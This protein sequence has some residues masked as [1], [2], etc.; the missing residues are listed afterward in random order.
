MI[1]KIRPK[2]LS[3]Q[4]CT[5]AIPL[6]SLYFTAMKVLPILIFSLV[7]LSCSDTAPPMQI[8]EAYLYRFDSITNQLGPTR[9]GYVQLVSLFELDKQTPN[10]FGS[11]PTNEHVLKVADTPPL[12]GYVFTFEDS[13]H[14][15]AAENVVINN[16]TGER[17]S[18]T[19]L[20]LDE[21]GNSDPLFSGRLK[22]IIKT[23]GN[24]KY[25]R[26]WDMENPLVNEFELFQL[27]PPAETFIFEGKYTEYDQPKE[28]MV[29]TSMSFIDEAA[30]VG[31]VTFDY[32]GSN[33]TL[34]V[35]ENG[36][37]MFADETSGV[38][39]Y[40]AGRYLYLTEPD[41][42]GNVILDFNY[43]Y[44]PPCSYSKF[45]TCRFPPLKNHLPFAIEAGEKIARR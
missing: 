30:F 37:L 14:F 33:Y 15:Q 9:T 20:S 41:N 40:G 17:I 26:I 38:T 8:D 12:L 31:N 2:H 32:E 21:Y 18:D 1:A 13:I 34:E 5:V 19:Y 25:L 44:N 35:E 7:V 36:F 27:Y 10:R 39:T 28:I 11:S 42:K 23:F 3:E 24:K 45:T 43:A 29:T 6:C 22:W 16:E 4:L